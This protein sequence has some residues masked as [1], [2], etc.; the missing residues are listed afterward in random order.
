MVINQIFNKHKVSV[1]YLH[2]H[3]L[4]AHEKVRPNGRTRMPQ[5]FI[6]LLRSSK[7]WIAN[8]INKKRGEDK[9]SIF[10]IDNSQFS[11]KRFYLLL[12]HDCPG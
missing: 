12:K 8:N 7:P 3:G 10:L 11:L 6:E 9:L 1:L 2:A 4:S 5:T